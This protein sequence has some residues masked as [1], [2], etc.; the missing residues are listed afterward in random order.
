MSSRLDSHRVTTTRASRPAAFVL[1]VLLS[2]LTL[3]A[4]APSAFAD[5]A[6]TDVPP[7]TQFY[8]EMAWMKATGISTGWPDGTYRP[9]ESV[10]RDAMAAFMYRL[11]GEP[12]FEAPAESPFT[13]ITPTTQFYKE[14]AWMKATGI[15]TG[16]DDGTYRPW[17]P[18]NRDAMAAFMYRLAGQPAFTP[19][20]T[21]PF[22]DITTTTQFYKEMSWMRATGI[23]TGWPDGTYRPLEPVLR[24]AMA[25]FMFRLDGWM[26]G[27]LLESIAAGDAHTCALTTGGGVKCWGSNAQGQ[28][29]DGTTTNRPTAVDVTGLSTGVTAITAGGNH[30]CAVFADGRVK[31][32]GENQYG[33]LGDG[34]TTQRST[35]V[36]VTG[37]ASGAIAISAGDFHTCA[38]TTGGGVKCWGNNGQGQLGN[39]GITASLTPVDV[40][41]LTSDV[42]AISANSWTTCA[43]ASGAARCWGNNQYGQLGDNTTTQR[44]TPVNVTGLTSGVTTVA[45]GEFH[46]CAITTGGKAMCWGNNNNGQLGD[47]TT[48]RSFTPVEVSGLTSGVATIDAGNSHTCAVTTGGGAKCWG[49]NGNGQVGDGT[50]TQRLRPVDV[51]SLTSGVSAVG[52]GDFHSCA[53]TTT[54]GA[55]CW[56]HNG[57]S[58]LGDGTTSQRTSPV[59]VVGH[60]PLAVTTSSLPN[61]TVGSSYSLTLTA[62]GGVAPHK[63]TTTSTLPS[64]LTLSQA[65]LLSGTPTVHTAGAVDVVV[66]VTD[67]RGGTNTANLKLTV[68]PAEL[69]I[70][71]TS[72]PNAT[73][74]EAYTQTL[75]A[76]GGVAPYT[77]STSTTLPAGLSLSASGVL[78]GT[79][80]EA[81]PSPV[82]IAVTVTDDWDASTTA[83][84]MLTVDPQPLKITTSS[85]PNAIVDTA[86]SRSLTATGGVAPYEWTTSTPLPDGL[87]LSSDGLLSG[88]PTTATTAAVSIEVTVTDDW[89]VTSTASLALSVLPANLSVIT[90]GLPDATV[91]DA[92]SAT[93]EAGGG[94]APYTWSAAGDLPGWLSL[95]ETGM[96]SGTPTSHTTAPITIWVTVTDSWNA[97]STASVTLEVN[98]APLLVTTSSLPD[99]KVGEAYPATTLSGAGGVAPYTWTAS[100]LPAGLSLSAEGV[101]T[102]TPEAHTP[103]PANV[104]VTVTDALSAST[105]VSLGL[106]VDPADL[107][108]TTSSLPDATV[109]SPYSQALAASG[110][111]TPYTWTTSSTLPEGL[112]LT[113]SGVLG[114]TAT[115]HTAEPASIEITVTDG[116]GSTST[117]TVMLTVKPAPLTITT[118][119]LADAT[120]GAFYTRT[121]VASGGVAP[122][123]WST[124]STLPDGLG[125]SDE[126]VL[127]GTPTSATTGPVNVVITVEDSLGA[128]RTSEL[129]LTVNAAPLVVQTTSLPNATV[130]APYTVTLL[131]SGGVAPYSWHAAALPDGLTLTDDG[132]LTGTPTTAAPT[133]TVDVTV[134]DARSQTA[135]ALLSLTVNPATLVVTTSS[136]PAAT[137]NEGYSATLEAAGGTAPYT[138]TTTSTLPDGLN[139]SSTGQLTGTP[140]TAGGTDIEVMV[141][142]ANNQTAQATLAITVN[143]APEAVSGG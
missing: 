11:A 22:T 48:A 80:S 113:T 72:L 108:V 94:V 41:G 74:S 87:A 67:A 63:W 19:P 50:T 119:S 85:L 27:G 138:W 120:V 65:G 134:T 43:V 30:T 57:Q 28:L 1:A 13:D 70:T 33:Q 137:I 79:P 109:G 122:Y 37:L 24:D 42:T 139:L 104:T 101:L 136:L 7:G 71:T 140:T 47:N 73:H 68:N 125:L 86:Y 142:D 95:S 2:L 69:E 131:A 84:L 112:S 54:G 98:P 31:C 96:L 25:A 58:R 100:G 127:S 75:S 105:S 111:V 91:G 60:E 130:G 93:L 114:G 3:G 117:A 116:R 99:G 56:G 78:S 10:N 18:V 29:G 45:A 129:Q 81:T 124:S 90:T 55:K 135:T 15:S 64:G 89:G 133:A 77:W 21:S 97:A 44:L 49:L 32:W 26:S 40:S 132:T 16:Y 92:Y 34:T 8:D 118:S 115:T 51:T 35:P 126:G 141:T 88:T 4:T 52:T 128:T 9:W 61:A 5:D 82:E 17:Q 14:M 36:D 83:S 23:S 62:I 39:G 76:T 46:T 102:G 143:P 110:G 6:F 66:T 20:A 38:I 123:T 103:S 53:L 121:L 59:D 107:V 106:T 12:A